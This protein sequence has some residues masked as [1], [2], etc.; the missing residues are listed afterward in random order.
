MVN[1][2]DPAIAGDDNPVSAEEGRYVRREDY[3]TLLK[4]FYAAKSFIQTHGCRDAFAAQFPR[5]WNAM[6]FDEPT[7]FELP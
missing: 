7:S 6:R 4:H 2:Y 5:T 3:D 1:Y